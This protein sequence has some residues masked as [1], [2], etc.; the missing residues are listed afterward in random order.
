MKASES[1]LAAMRQTNEVFDAE[2][3]RKG[4]INELD[5]V[6]TANARI[7]P[8]GAPMVE[9]RDQIKSFWQQAIAGLDVKNATLATEAADAV[10][11]GVV[12]IGR[13]DLTLGNGQ[14]V[15]AKYVVCWRQED[16]HWKW[17]VDIWNFNQ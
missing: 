15:T 7:L 10:G 1:V 5:R 2:V 6:Y 4:N 12:E 11:D 3:V 9:G 16:G 8:P 13:A 14:S 17:H